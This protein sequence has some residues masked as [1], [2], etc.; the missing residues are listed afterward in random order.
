MIAIQ[1]DAPSKHIVDSVTLGFT[2]DPIARWLYPEPHTFLEHWPTTVKLFGGAALDCNTA[3]HVTDGGAAA[4]WLPP[5]AHP[6]GDGLIAHFE[7]VLSRRVLEDAYKVSEIMEKFHPDEACWH[8][9]FVATDPYP[10]EGVWIGTCRPYASA[11]RCGT[12]DRLSREYQSGEHRLVSAARLPG[13]RRNASREISADVC[14]ATGTLLTR[15]C[16]P[17]WVLPTL[18]A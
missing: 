12:Q 7:G 13:D 5:G 17:G 3:F 8:L 6:D 11:L 1:N 16:K 2:A 9:A 10:A 4:M 18:A 15:H 14:D